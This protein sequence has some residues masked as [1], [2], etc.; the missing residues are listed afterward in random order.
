M[1]DYTLNSSHS[2]IKLSRYLYIHIQTT[3]L[4]YIVYSYYL[5]VNVYVCSLEEWLLRKYEGGSIYNGN[6]LITQPTGALEFYTLY[7]TK[8][9]GFTFSMVH[10]I[11][12]YLSDLISYRLLK[13]VYI[14][15][16]CINS[17]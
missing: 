7:G 17:S 3:W 13:K 5:V 15:A 14:Y 16:L 8:D 2:G 6:T 10:K 11:L 9:Q 4:L 1:Y 12:F